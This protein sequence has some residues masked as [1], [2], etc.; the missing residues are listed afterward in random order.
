MKGERIKCTLQKRGGTLI[1]FTR[2]FETCLFIFLTLRDNPT[3]FG[4][5]KLSP[6]CG[7]PIKMKDSCRKVNFTFFQKL[8]FWQCTVPWYHPNN[9]SV[10][11]IQQSA[12]ESGSTRRR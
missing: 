2:N 3:A 9:E 10:P 12:R 5:N 1:P 8:I 6:L 7:F 4:Q 11:E